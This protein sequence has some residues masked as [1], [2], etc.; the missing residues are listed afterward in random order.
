MRIAS[1]TTIIKLKTWHPMHVFCDRFCEDVR[2]APQIQF[3]KF[4]NSH[5]WPNDHSFAVERPDDEY[6]ELLSARYP[7]Y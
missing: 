5:I 1:D 2:L 4:G 3:E 7:L 6:S